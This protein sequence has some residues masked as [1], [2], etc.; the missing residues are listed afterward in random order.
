MKK[1]LNDPKKKDSGFFEENKQK[2]D[3]NVKFLKNVAQVEG[4]K[5]KESVSESVPNLIS[6]CHRTHT[7]SISNYIYFFFKL[8]I[9]VLNL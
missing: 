7:H 5:E 6:D 8:P 9:Q 2:N 4:K 1:Y 3:W